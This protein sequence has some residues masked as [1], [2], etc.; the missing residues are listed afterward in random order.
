MRQ[1]PAPRQTLKA[2]LDGSTAVGQHVRLPEAPL[3]GIAPPVQNAAPHVE[4]QG[5]LLEPTLAGAAQLTHRELRSLAGGDDLQPIDPAST[6]LHQP[7]LRTGFDT[8]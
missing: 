6:Q 5:M 1:P 4:Q 7:L 3:G 8:A 2:A